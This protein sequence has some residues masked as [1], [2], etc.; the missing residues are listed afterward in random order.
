MKNKKNGRRAREPI[1]IIAARR[2]C[3]N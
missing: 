2:P 3:D 1:E